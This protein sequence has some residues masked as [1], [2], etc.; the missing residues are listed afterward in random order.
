MNKRNDEKLH[1]LRLRSHDRD[2]NCVLAVK[3][4]TLK[5][6]EEGKA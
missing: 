2:D 3:E 1:L 4:L 6:Q 5:N